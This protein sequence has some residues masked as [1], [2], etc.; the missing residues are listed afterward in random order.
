MREWFQRL[1]APPVFAEDEEKTRIA[2]LLTPMLHTLLGFL[3][4]G[5]LA[6]LLITP[7]RYPTTIVV[8]ILAG[9]LLAA[10]IL[11]QRGQ[12]R[13]ACRLFISVSGLGI[14]LMVLFAGGITSFTIVL[15]IALVIVSALFL[16]RLATTLLTISIFLTEIGVVILGSADAMPHQYFSLL[17][18]SHLALLAV[19]AVLVASTLNLALHSLDESRARYKQELA[20]RNQFE[21]ALV[22]SELRF[23]TIFDSVNDA[24]I[25]QDYDTGAIL[26]VNQRMCEMYGY[27]HQEAL[28]LTMEDLS[29]GESPYTQREAMEWIRRIPRGESQ[30]AEWRARDKNG[31]L[32]WAEINIRYADIAGQERL[33]VTVRDINHR[34]R[35]DQMRT[36][37]YQISDAARAAQ[38]LNDFYRLIHTVIRTLMP[39]RNFYI[40][41]YQP[42][43]NLVSYPYYADDF[44]PPPP[45]HQPDRGLTTYV[46][47]TGI[48]MLA[49]PDV[50]DCLVAEGEVE[51]VG[52]PCID[53]LGAP[54]KTATEVIGVLAVQTYTETERLTADDRDL[55]V[56]VSN[57]V[58]LMLERMQAE[59]HDRKLSRGLHAIVDSA[60]ELIGCENLDTLFRRAVELG[61]EKLNVERCAI[62]LLDEQSQTL[63]G[64]YGTD[65]KG[66]TTDER[67]VRWLA[68]GLPEIFVGGRQNRLIREADL[69]V[70]WRN[71]IETKLDRGWIAYTLIRI[72]D[73]PIGVF[74]N[75]SAISHTPPE[76]SIQE[77]VAIYCSLLGNIIKR[78]RVEAE[79]IKLIAELEAKNS[80]LER[81]SY[82]VS[83]DLK[84]PLITI[85]GFLG[86]LEKDANSGNVKR[87]HEDMTRISEAT[88]KM[89][90]LL[91]ELLELSRIGR[92]LNPGQLVPFEEIAREAME[93][94]RGQIEAC[95]AE[96]IVQDGMPSVYVDRARLVEVVQN[97]LDN[98]VKFTRREI[99]P[100]IEIGSR[101]LDE[102][103]RPILFVRDNGIGIDPQYHER[104][105]GLF[106]K[107]DNQS[108][109]T[110]IGLALVKRIIE[111]HGGRIWVESSGKDQGSTFCFSLPVTPPK[112]G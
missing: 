91:N 74:C 10:R 112:E 46:L 83:H 78:M 88:N 70:Y 56:F 58:A 66:R 28:Q 24:I 99:S 8:F 38:D 51:N 48:P 81:F 54:L 98:A 77:T 2:N 80:E 76:E 13:N 43:I 21:K 50:F 100:R 93:I 44:D 97:L 26:D 20:E 90:Q 61:R 42:D 94:V 37:L 41:L 67:N 5:G 33:L 111:F 18:G 75:D 22:E 65:D 62:F 7:E 36:A 25:I 79:Q 101:G 95:G 105:F 45:P 14:F 3:I 108:E 82:T 104:V 60:D 92:L 11:L 17:P 12:V 53:W 103:G 72:G 49:T 110:G 63:L 85:R 68:E 9:T 19:A 52:T 84:A 69:R 32:F 31:R 55:L 1:F 106:N 4:L 23:H 29:L 30:L 87:L 34:K 71:G 109:G 107:L 39:A 64:T 89:Q 6:I 102:K 96:I 27:T 73:E 86:Y 40:A 59:V 35:A 57:Q 15:Y 16:G 47:H